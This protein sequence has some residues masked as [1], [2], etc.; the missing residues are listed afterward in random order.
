MK[1]AKIDI[2][3]ARKEFLPS[4]TSVVDDVKKINL[5]MSRTIEDSYTITHE[6]F[7]FDNMDIQNPTINFATNKTKD[8]S[9][10]RIQK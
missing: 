6:F 10:F 9:I 8:S 1:S 7:H 5:I 3:V 2:R 4:N